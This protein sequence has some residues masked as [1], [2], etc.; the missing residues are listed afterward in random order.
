VTLSKVLWKDGD[1]VTEN[2]FRGLE[3]WVESAQALLALQGG[4]H[5]MLRVAEVDGIFND[6]SAISIKNVQGIQYRAKIEKFCALTAKG[7]IVSL[8]GSREFELTFRTT[9]RDREGYYHIFLLPASDPGP[10]SAA[11]V[12]AGPI[13]YEPLFRAQTTDDLHEGFCIARLKADGP[14]I[15]FD[16]EFLP[17]C[18]TVDASPQS[19]RRCDRIFEDYQR[20]TSSVEAYIRALVNRTGMEPVWAFAKELF[21]LLCLFK[22]SFSGRSQLSQGYFLKAQEFIDAV[23]GELAILSSEYKEPKLLGEIHATIERLSNPVTSLSLDINMGKAYDAV[24]RSLETVMQLLSR[25]PEGP[26]IEA[27]LAVEEM[28]FTKGTAYNKLSIQ[29]VEEVS[30]SKDGSR[31]VFTFRDFSSREP[32]ASDIRL[33]L[34]SDLPYGSLPQLNDLLK[35]VSTEEFDFR[36]ECPGGLLGTGKMRKLTLYLP[37]P[38]GENVESLRSRVTVSLIS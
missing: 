1:V 2:H 28:T 7:Q 24:H 35:R 19:L 36:I 8:F 5:G 6:M 21:R 34:G 12:G 10:E 15:T 31:L 20:M 23:A 32:S 3:A 16:P 33:A 4:G 22:H 26:A 38:L 29:F 9:D 14:S 37:P 27:A 17:L 11:T 13:L 30:Y 18:L 25:F